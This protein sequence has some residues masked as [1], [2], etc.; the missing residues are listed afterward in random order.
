MAGYGGDGGPASEALLFNPSGVTVDPAGQAYIADP[1]NN[2][3]RTSAVED[4]C[5]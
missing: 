5:P 4:E 1:G 2:R 3:V